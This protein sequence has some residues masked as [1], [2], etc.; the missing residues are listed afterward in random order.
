MIEDYRRFLDMILGIIEIVG[1]D[2]R[3]YELD[4]MCWRVETEEQ[5]EEYKEELSKM[6][7]LLVESEVKGRM[8]SVYKL[9]KPLVYGERVIDVIELPAPKE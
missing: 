7:E 6:G 1:I 2:V 5:Y 8:I 4:H 9:D 3:G